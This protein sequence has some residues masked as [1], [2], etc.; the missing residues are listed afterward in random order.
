MNRFLKK[1]RRVVVSGQLNQ[2]LEDEAAFHLEMKAEATGQPEHRCA[3]FGHPTR[4]QGGLSR[5]VDVVSLVILA[6]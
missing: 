3:S 1:A 6:Q 5:H 2:D 4:A